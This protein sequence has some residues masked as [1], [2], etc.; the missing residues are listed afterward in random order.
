MAFSLQNLRM[1]MAHAPRAARVTVAWMAL[2]LAFASAP[3]CEPIGRAEAAA[4]PVALDVNPHAP[5]ADQ[6]PASGQGSCIVWLDVG[7]SAADKSGAWVPFA[8]KV[9]AGAPRAVL[10]PVTTD[11]N[12]WQPHRLSVSSPEIA[13]Y[14]R[15]ARLII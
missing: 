12:A 5:P 4:A 6:A 14:L 9:P 2:S 15:H 1:R 8:A 10:M 11:V 7:D 13:L 3:C